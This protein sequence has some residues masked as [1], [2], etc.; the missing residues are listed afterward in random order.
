MA[1]R[2]EVLIRYRG[3]P[4]PVRAGETL[5]GALVGRGLPT[6]QRS[7]RY[8]RP[9]APFCG[10]GACTNCLVRVNG[11][12]LVRACRY[13]PR[14]GDDVRTENAW[15]SPQHDL[16]GVLDLLL[17]RGLDTLRGL[18]RP[19]A[20]RPLY[21]RI[22]RRLAGYGR[23]ADRPGAP[24][25]P[26]ERRRAGV[27]VVGA[28]PAGRAAAARAASHGEGV[29]L[30]DRGPLAAPP[31]GVDALGGLTV[32]FL[33]PPTGDPRIFRALATDGRR[34]LT[35]EAPRV[36]LAPGAYDAALLFT[37]N[38]RPGV[39][40]AEGALALRDRGG[41]PPFRRALL[42]GGGARALAMLER[43][44]GRF[45]A[46]VA[47]G[48]VHGAIAERAAHLEIPVHPRSLLLAAEGRGR[49]RSVRWQRRGGGAM[50]RLGADAV[51]LAHRR[52][53][54]APLL[55]Q[56]GAGMHWRGGAGAYY[57]VLADGCAST[58][59]GLFV[60][61]EAAG[62]T[63]PIG[64]EASGL[65][66]GEGVAGGPAPLATLPPRV[67]EAGPHELEG[68]YRE[69]LGLPPPR[70]KL[71]ACAC[72]DVL[73]AE[74]VDAHRR[75]YRG[76]EVIKRYTSLGTG[77]CQGR[78]CVPEALLLLGGW[79][80]RSPAEVGYLTQRPPVLPTPLGALAALAEEPEAVA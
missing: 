44:G 31:E 62:F 51:V 75:G 48:P 56:A 13:L 21:Q 22:V 54:N 69:L 58:V 35:L 4:V 37:G 18:R 5:L 16:L 23:I 15:P 68:Y 71:L 33:P 50:E 57:P 29:L 17:P 28:G 78:Y 76:I 73:L 30:V 55:F 7:I 1:E 34:G 65:A 79:E 43:F 36:V 25:P 10:V 11:E 2:G 9:R 67:A 60:A 63:D 8:H 38:D 72:E 45:A 39:M 46:V 47:P 64:I 3:R 42:V 12:P 19:A 61:G 74:L 24:A 40:T 6:L 14:P 70:G 32:V 80:G 77:L 26:G 20:M 41:D 59:P 53:P 49:V 66:A 52:L 27:L